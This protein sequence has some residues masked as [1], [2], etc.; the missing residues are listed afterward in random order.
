[1]T[2][3]ASSLIAFLDRFGLPTVY[4]G[5]LAWLAWKTITGPLMVLAQAGVAYLAS[6]TD[7]LN[8]TH[9]EHVELKAHV[10]AESAA[11][12]EHVT[13]RVEAIRDRV[14]A[15]ENSIEGTV[16]TST[17]EHRAYPGPPPSRSG[18]PT[19]PGA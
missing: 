4:L 17:G 13:S 16:R 12:R 8:R 18:T 2:I 10:S 15:A 1:M 6:A 3:D 9:V 5:V 11:T 14:S 7:S 19:L